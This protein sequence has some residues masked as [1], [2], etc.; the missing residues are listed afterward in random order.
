MSNTVD[1]SITKPVG[2]TKKG[3]RARFWFFTWNNYPV[4]GINTL[5]AAFSDAEKY[6]FQE[7][8]GEE[9]TP[10]IQGVVGWKSAKDFNTLKKINDKIHW[11]KSRSEAAYKYCTKENTRIGSVHIKGYQ[12]PKPIITEFKEWQTNL[13]EKIKLEPDPRKIYWIVDPVGG[14][15]KTTFCKHLV[16]TR[17]D[18]IYICG[19]ASDMKYGIASWL[20]T[21][22]MNIALLDYTRSLENFISYEGIESVKNGI[23]Y[24]TKYES[25][26][27][28]FDVP[29]VICFSNFEPNL[30]MLSKDRW[31][32]I[33]LSA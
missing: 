24:N 4:E 16:S 15:G 31:E 29:H 11:E 17:S 33:T 10:H 3:L 26:M 2:N 9:G 25:K 32:V 13:L 30:D 28:I 12:I 18:T 8:Q 22:K 6:A 5:K 27:V 21:K 20:E 1:T 19:K 14:Q 23:Y 7:E